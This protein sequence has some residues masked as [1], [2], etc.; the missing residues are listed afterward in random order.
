MSRT[1]RLWAGGTVRPA[2]AFSASKTFN[3]NVCAGHD[4]FTE[5][6]VFI[7]IRGSIVKKQLSA[8]SLRALAYSVLL[9][10]GQKLQT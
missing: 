7:D 3:G 9:L 5:C 8:A 4:F 10:F 1:E 6:F 2:C